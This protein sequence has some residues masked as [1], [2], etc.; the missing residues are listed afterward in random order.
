[1]LYLFD[2]F[3]PIINYHRYIDDVDDDGEKNRCRRIFFSLFSLY[4]HPIQTNWSTNIERER[5]QTH[6][7][8]ICRSLMWAHMLTCWYLCFEKPVPKSS[9]LMSCV[10]MSTWMRTSSINMT[11]YTL[12]RFMPFRLITWSSLRDMIRVY[13]LWCVDRYCRVR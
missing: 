8:I 6:F 10:Y 1:M 3:T 11:T 2:D 5:H 4:A 9:I 13:S 12:K 7:I